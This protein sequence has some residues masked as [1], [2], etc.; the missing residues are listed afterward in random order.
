M[1]EANLAYEKGEENRLREILDEYNGV[2]ANL[3]FNWCRQYR[4]GD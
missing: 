2:N 1:T 3:V 4:R